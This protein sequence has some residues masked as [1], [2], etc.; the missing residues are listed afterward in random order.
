[1][2]FSVEVVNLFLQRCEEHM[3]DNRKHG[4]AGQGRKIQ[5]RQDWYEDLC[6]RL[7]QR[8]KL[9]REL[10]LSPPSG[11]E[12]L[13]LNRAD[14]QEVPKQRVIAVEECRCDVCEGGVKAGG[15][16]LVFGNRGRGAILCV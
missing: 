10:G 3:K 9:A 16:T 1:M 2:A 11:R 6:N 4:A 8:G 7:A 12:R 5:T 13:P 14:I 15:A